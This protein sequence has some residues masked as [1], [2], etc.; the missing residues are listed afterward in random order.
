M[1][2]R[3]KRVG[4]WAKWVKGSGRYR[5][6]VIEQRSH[7]N[8]SYSIGNTINGIVIMLYGDEW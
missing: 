3:G 2:A 5:L 4:G 8:K 7:G 1:V 6:P